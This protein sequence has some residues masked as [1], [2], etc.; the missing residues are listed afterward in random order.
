MISEEQKLAD[1]D[2]DFEVAVD[3]SAKER[4]LKTALWMVGKIDHSVH[5]K[6]EFRLRGK[7]KGDQV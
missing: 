6:R 3:E 7:C 2:V 5:A 1:S 4:R